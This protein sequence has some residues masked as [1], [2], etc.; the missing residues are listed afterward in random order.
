LYNYRLP[1]NHYH[2]SSYDQSGRVKAV[3]LCLLGEHCNRKDSAYTI[4]G[5]KINPSNSRGGKYKMIIKISP[6]E[7]VPMSAHWVGTGLHEGKFFLFYEMNI[8]V[9]EDENE[10]ENK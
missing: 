3:K 5:G 4:R 8:E 1:A 10:K 6:G 9:L 7:I 2:S